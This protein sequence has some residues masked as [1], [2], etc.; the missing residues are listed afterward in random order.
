MWRSGTSSPFGSLDPDCV[1]G[2][3]RPGGARQLVWPGGRGVWCP[4]IGTERT[5]NL[6]ESLGGLQCPDTASDTGPGAEC[7]SEGRLE[8]PANGPTR[9]VKNDRLLA[10]VLGDETHH[11]SLIALF[12]FHRTVSRSRQEALRP[13]DG[14]V[15]CCA[16]TDPSS[17][18][19]DPPNSRRGKACTAESCACCKS[20]STSNARNGSR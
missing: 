20:I 16:V 6:V 19:G 3:S 18:M 10:G 17:P 5:E 12:A 9:E 15:M 2:A 8:L 11:E 7:V 14:P 4:Q 13:F 1:L